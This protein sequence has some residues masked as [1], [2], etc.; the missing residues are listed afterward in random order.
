MVPTMPLPEVVANLVLGAILSALAALA[1]VRAR[2]LTADG[3]A[4]ATIVGTLTLGFGGWG[5]AALLGLFFLSSSLLTRWRGG[6]KP[7]DDPP[8][9]RTAS[10]VLANGGVPAILAVSLGLSRGGGLGE[11]GAAWMTPAVA[12]AAAAIAAATA[13]TWATELGLA[14][15]TPPRLITTGRPVPAGTSGGVTA[16]G[17]LA[18]AAG[19]GLIA[20]AGQWWLGAP[21]WVSFPVGVGA[22]ALDSVLGA[23]VE[24]RRAGVTND[25]VNLLAGLAAAA[26]G[27]GLVLVR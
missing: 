12:A 7:A 22:M 2:F 1:S 8:G 3:A 4:A 15:R 27:A 10:Q 17:T 25:T 24:G 11:A 18:A 13:D 16:A 19:A 9:A 14:S 5:V 21:F 6:A 26:A 20:A 23:T